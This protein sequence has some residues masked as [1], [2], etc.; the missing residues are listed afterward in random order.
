MNVKKKQHS[1]RKYL[2]LC[3][4]IVFVA[5]GG[6]EEEVCVEKTWYADVDND[7]LGNPDVSKTACS[8]PLG[9]VDNN[10]DDNDNPAPV[11][12][13][14]ETQINSSFIGE[15]Y[16]LRIFLPVDYETKN[17]PVLY[18]LDGKTYFDDVIKWQGEIELEAII[19]GVGDHLFNEEFDFRR[20][21]FLP[22]FAYNGE[23]G[24]HIDFYNFLTKELIP[25]IDENYENDHSKRSL[26][27]H[28]AAG[29]FTN[30]ALLYGA[31]EEQIFHG[32]LS[33][34]AEIL[35]FFILIDLA[36]NLSVGPDSDIFLH[37]SQV[38][39]SMKAEWFNDLLIE[40]NYPW[41]QIDLMTI[42]DENSDAFNPTV[43]EPSV[44][45]G[46]QFIY[47]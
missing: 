41:L 24:G 47:D 28:H 27:G 38:S 44:K 1:W 15:N 42:E 34:N 7:G 5:C 16:P 25:F 33:I 14:L 30:F 26:I 23:K 3:L 8:Q 40:H 10:N 45:R 6:S 2:F 11:A 37:H 21:D 36:E 19:V 43:V 39:S 31:D 12:Q 13:R 20:R 4:T 17:L 32:Y 9:Y 35:N 29:L 18:V 22:D 46:L